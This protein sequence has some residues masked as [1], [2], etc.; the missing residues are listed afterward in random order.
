MF[1]FSTVVLMLKTHRITPGSEYIK[2]LV[3]TRDITVNPTFN[4]YLVEFM[5]CLNEDICIE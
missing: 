1:V 4:G 2:K 3:T 5:E